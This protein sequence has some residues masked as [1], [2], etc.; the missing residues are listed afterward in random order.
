MSDSTLR[1]IASVVPSLLRELMRDTVGMA[2]PA[3]PAHFRLIMPEAE[4]TK[5]S[6]PTQKAILALLKLM[7]HFIELTQIK[8]K[9]T[10]NKES[11]RSIQNA[12]DRIDI[13]AEDD[14]TDIFTF[15][16]T[17]FW[18]DDA[19]AQLYKSVMPMMTAYAKAHGL[20]DEI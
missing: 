2:A 4:E 14:S 9:M 12:L 18:E 16:S 17:G 19:A 7:P 5:I 11:S 1:T 10:K 20:K 6:A 3:I 15:D 13:L 8:E